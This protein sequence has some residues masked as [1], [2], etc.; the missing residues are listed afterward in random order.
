MEDIFE[1]SKKEIIKRYMFF[2]VGLFINALGVS[3]ITKTSL[4]TSPISSIPY[5]LSMGFPLTMGV[6][7]FL[8]NMIL[9]LGQILL[10]KKDFKK[11]QLLQIPVSV[12]FGYFIDFTM[13]LLSFLNPT[14]YVVRI[15]CLL[16]GC[17]ILGLGISMEVIADVVMLSGEAFVKAISSTIKRE[18]GTTKILFDATLTITACIISLVMFHEI[19]GVREGTVVAA[20]I[21][22]LI[23]KFLSKK[24]SFIEQMLIDKNSIA[25]IET[26]EINNQKRTIIT[27]SREF[28]SGGH[29]IGQTIANALGIAFYD[30]QII[31]L[32][33][34]E[35][36]FSQEYVQEHEQK[37]TNSF[38]YDLVMQNYSYTKNDLPPL[39]ALFVA[40]SK[41]IRKIANKESCV[42]VGRCANHILRDR[43]DCF[44]VFI[45]SDKKKRMKHIVEEYAIDANKAEAELQKT[46][47]ERANHYKRYTDNIWG[48]AKNYHLTIDSG[49]FGEEG[50]AKVIME[51][52]KEILRC[53]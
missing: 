26:E 3:F 50:T 6:F 13:S 1:M 5:T 7:T 49:L 47:K 39:D 30:E 29:K 28:G 38:L 8:L 4:G 34:Q 35:S 52:A 53:E 22:G 10:L 20:L 21:V 2:A 9:I 15:I 33:A 24:L 45:H 18:F 42:I 37:M 41:V 46:D 43:T 44:H 40:E 12:A 11:I 31:G 23:A 19:K 25:L 27:I 14:D 36:G 17:T 48:A 32:A 51:S 16:A